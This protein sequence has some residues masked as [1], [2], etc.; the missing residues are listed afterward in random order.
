MPENL[1]RSELIE[2]ACYEFYKDYRTI[3]FTADKMGVGQSTV[4]RYFAK[5]SKLAIE[6]NNKEFIRRQK[7]TKDRVLYK[8]DCLMYKAEKQLKRLNKLL[9]YN[10]DDSSED[11]IDIFELDDISDRVRV[12]GLINKIQG[13]LI[14][15][16]QQKASIEDTP[17][18]D[19]NIELA[20]QDRL[21]DLDKREQIIMEKEKKLKK[22]TN[23]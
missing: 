14:T 15:W 16:N 19:V 6:E 3:A 18:M 7:I 5:F 8:L 20:V 22:I 10:E 2:E 11:E 13:D 23:K 12:E 1:R 17:T 21:E 4:Q 9:G